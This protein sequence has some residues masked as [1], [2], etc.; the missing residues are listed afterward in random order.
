MA[1]TI[2][3]GVGA[4]LGLSEASATAPVGHAPSGVVQCL[5][6]TPTPKTTEVT[7]AT[8][9][10]YRVKEMADGFSSGLAISV[11]FQRAIE[12]PAGFDACM[13]AAMERV[14]PSDESSVS[15]DPTTSILRAISTCGGPAGTRHV[16]IVS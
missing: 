5:V 7:C 1:L 6:A 8:P 2:G 13:T 14:W 3:A 10:S 12:V 15:N 4:G 11:L 9:A 16:L